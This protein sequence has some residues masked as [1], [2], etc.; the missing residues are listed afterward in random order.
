MALSCLQAADESTLMNSF[1]S[2][3]CLQA[4]LPQAVTH[5][6]LSSCPSEVFLST[7]R[8]AVR[9]FTESPQMIHCPWKCATILVLTSPNDA[10]NS[11]FS[12]CQLFPFCHWSARCFQLWCERH[13]ALWER[14]VIRNKNKDFCV[15]QPYDPWLYPSR[16]CLFNHCI[17]S[18]SFLKHNYKVGLVRLKT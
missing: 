9:Q 11:F 13:P 16:K 2:E 3:S 15:P 14:Q 5:Q 6:S 17:C 12:L 7:D 18:C 8:A 1:I 4:A 10:L